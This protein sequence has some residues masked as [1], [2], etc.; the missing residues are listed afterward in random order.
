MEDK[1]PFPNVG[2]GLTA[3]HEA[4][5]VA[6]LSGSNRQAMVD[7]WDCWGL[8]SDV[9]L[10]LS[11]E[12]GTK[13]MLLSQLLQKGYAPDHVLMVGDDPGDQTAS[14][15]CGVLFY[16][17]RVRWEGQDWATLINEALPRLL[18]GTYRDWGRERARLFRENLQT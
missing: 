3:A 18:N 13:H 12:D 16:P 2:E 8:L 15:R 14:V 17:I 4:A 9:D 6:V 10:A 11:Q 5:D 7:E 1:V